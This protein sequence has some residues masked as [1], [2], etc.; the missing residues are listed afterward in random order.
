METW[1][2]LPVKS[3]EEERPYKEAQ[4]NLLNE[5]GRKPRESVVMENQKRQIF[6]LH[7]CIVSHSQ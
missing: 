1:S 3:Q 5:L 4:R 7:P 2:A 6:Y